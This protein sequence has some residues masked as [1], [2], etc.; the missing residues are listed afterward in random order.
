MKLI[1]II[2]FLFVFSLN[3]IELFDAIKASDAVKLTNH[4]FLI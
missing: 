1:L 3:A 4:Y 2:L